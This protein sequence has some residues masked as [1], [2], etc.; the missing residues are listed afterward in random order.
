M[1]YAGYGA[2]GYPAT[3]SSGFSKV[4]PAYGK[5]VAPGSFGKGLGKGLGKGFGKG[6]FGK[7]AGKGAGKGVGK[8]AGKGFGKGA[9]KGFGKGTGKGAGGFGKGYPATKSTGYSA[10]VPVTSVATTP[11][12]GA[13]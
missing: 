3:I 1:N 9:G 8:G 6:A 7:G 12:P 5:A 13:I 2:G 4:V 10:A 11:V